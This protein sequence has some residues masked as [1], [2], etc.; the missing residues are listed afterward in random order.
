MAKLKTVEPVVEQRTQ[1]PAAIYEP[2]Q[3]EIQERAYYRYVDRGRI[4]GF[5][6]EDWYFAETELRGGEQPTVREPDAFSRVPEV[7]AAAE[8]HASDAKTGFVSV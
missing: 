2:T 4:D 7:A 5:D 3:A 1:P 6:R 8:V